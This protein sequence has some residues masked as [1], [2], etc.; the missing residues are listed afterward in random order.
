MSQTSVRVRFSEVDS[1]HVVWHGVYVK[2]FEDGREAFGRQYAGIGYMDFFANGFATP[3][4]DLQIQYKKSL[5]YDDV[6]IVEVYYVETEASKICFEYVIRNEADGTVVATG[7]TVQ[8]FIDQ[9][10]QLQL[11][12]P[13]FYLKWKE[14]WEL[15]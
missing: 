7:S 5:R 8:V 6:A 1:M 4:V 9:Q 2:Y 15:K 10:G 11:N 14:K 3:I 12:S 13:E